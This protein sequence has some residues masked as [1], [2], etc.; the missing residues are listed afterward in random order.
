MNLEFFRIVNKTREMPKTNSNLR[1]FNNGV[2]HIV[3][4]TT[5]E[6]NPEM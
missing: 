1:D 3:N 4:I 5:A 2:C 6:S